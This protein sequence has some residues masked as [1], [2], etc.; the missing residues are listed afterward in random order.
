MPRIQAEFKGDTKLFTLEI[1]SMVLTKMRETGEAFVVNE[2]EHGV[3]NKNKAALFLTCHSFR[4]MKRLPRQKC[5]ALFLF[6]TLWVE[7]AVITCPAHFNDSQ[8][9]ATKDTRLISG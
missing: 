4:P 3:P 1:S 6:G 5:A 8:R 2:V 7:I 9:Q